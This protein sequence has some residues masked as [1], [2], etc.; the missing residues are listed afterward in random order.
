VVLEV[1]ETIWGPVVDR[2]HR[3]RERALRWVA[4]LLDATDIGLLALE[5]VRTVEEALEAAAGAGMPAQ[6]FVVADEGGRIGWSVAGRIPLRAPGDATRPVSWRAA[7][8]PWTA[9][10]DAPSYPRVVD[11]ESGRLWTANNRVV[12]PP[13]LDPLGDGGFDL[14]ARALQI[15]DGLL[16]LDA[17]SEVDLLAIQLDHR[18][19]FLAPWRE[20]LLEVLKRP[21]AAAADPRRAELARRVERDWSGRASIDSVAYRLV[22]S[23]RYF[24]ARQIFRSLAAPAVAVD[25][26]LGWGSVTAQYEGPLWRLVT[27]R[28]EHLLDPRFATWDEQLL[29]AVDELLDEYADDA[30]EIDFAALTWGARNTVRV[31]HPLSLAVPRLARWLDI[32][33]RPLPGDSHMPRVQ[34][35]DFGASERFVVSPGREENGIFHM[36]GGQSGHFLSPFYRIG[37]EAWAAGQATP[38]LPG[39]ARH[40]LTLRPRAPGNAG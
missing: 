20:L 22:R 4:H 35:P 25:A 39:P 23:F 5:H 33:P 3:E 28:P 8:P 40:H 26:D 32:P 29:A 38:F 9:W 30:G 14:G 36:P 24:L 27:E 19:L 13:L 37:H 17:A 18:A 6:N 12:D 7:G 15:R 10:L 1:L 16:R 2:D 11:P 34:A 21:G 31:G